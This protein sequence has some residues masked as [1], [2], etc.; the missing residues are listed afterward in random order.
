MELSQFMVL[1]PTQSCRVFC[2]RFSE[3]TLFPVDYWNNRLNLDAFSSSLLSILLLTCMVHDLSLDYLLMRDYSP[4]AVKRN[5]EPLTE[6]QQRR[7]SLFLHA[8]PAARDLALQEA[9][10]RITAN[11]SIR[12]PLDNLAL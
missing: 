12:F 7:L 9:I 2:S 4:I 10:L 6:E 8:T 5:G 3:N 1:A 11:G